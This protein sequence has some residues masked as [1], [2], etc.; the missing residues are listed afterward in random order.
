MHKTMNGFKAKCLLIIFLSTLIFS[1]YG[2]EDSSFSPSKDN[3]DYVYQAKAGDFAP[4]Q[5]EAHYRKHGYQF[6]NISQEEYLVKARELL[7]A[8][9]GKDVLEKTRPNGDVLHYRV[10]T[11]EFAVMAGNGRIR[12]YFKADYKYWMHQ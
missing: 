1:C 6:G 11:K 8:P 4:G 7:N 3:V 2:E 10:S 9:A 5:L 12:T